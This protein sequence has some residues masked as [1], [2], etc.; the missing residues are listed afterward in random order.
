M[1]KT[2]EDIRLLDFFEKEWNH[3]FEENPEYATFLGNHNYN[4]R[5]N[6]YS[7]KNL[8][9]Q[10]EYD[11]KV[12]ETLKNF[13]LEELSESEKLSYDLFSL[14]TLENLESYKYKSYLTPLNQM[15]GFHTHFARLITMMPF[16]KEKDYENYLSR[17]NGFQAVIDQ[18][19][20]LMKKGIEENIT[21][22]QIVM[23]NVPLQIKNQLAEDVKASVFY[24]PIT[25]AKDISTELLNKIEQGIK[26]KIYTGFTKLIDFL[27]K[28]YIPNCR[29]SIGISEIPQGKEFYNFL[30]KEFTT[31]NLTAEEI[32]QIGLKEVER[33]F[34]E[35][36]ILIKKAGFDDYEKFLNHLKTCP[37]FY[38]Q[39]PETLLMH[40]RDFCKR[41]DKE[42]PAFFKVLP[43]ITYGVEKVPDYQ[44]PSATTAYYMS[45]DA[46]MTRAGVF[47]ANTYQLENRPKYEIEALTLH[48]A[49]PGHHLQLSLA[50]ELQNLPKFRKMARFISYI[51]GWGLYSE[52]LGAEM[53]F[54]KD[55]F[56]KFGQLIFEIRRACRLVIDTGIHAFG[57]DRSKA[58]EYIKYYTG[59]SES[60]CITEINRYIAMPAQA[61]SYKIGELK[62]LEIR[63]KF[64]ET[65]G[66]K[67]DI[68]EF[69]DI[70]LKN[71]ALP[72]SVL[73]EYAYGYLKERN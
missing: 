57:W 20:E 24:E 42:L 30:L 62:I 47:Y 72:L 15:H 31:T 48:E 58:I 6:D 53:G 61:T 29:S 69:H 41:V 19:I 4:D 5:L 25:K 43:R 32:H 59:K 23:K 38:F 37:D 11:K 71:G 1:Q 56:S 67:F 39:D 65:L 13:K 68:R 60:H 10:I 22:P 17:I 45:P 63:K 14:K 36:Q 50:L 3:T 21:V 35:M 51:E 66:D 73:E 70:I 49:V 9:N 27:E 44:A 54:Y 34:S 18:L 64:E 12:L 46:T 26:E 33:I 8:L 28:E 16:N 55:I 7:E 2:A 52:K 40:Y